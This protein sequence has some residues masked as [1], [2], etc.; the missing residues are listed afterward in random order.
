VAVP[1]GDSPLTARY[2]KKFPRSAAAALRLD[3]VVAGG[4]THDA[5]NLRPFGVLV[6]RAAGA[7]KWT[8]EGVRLID[9]W[10][11]HGALLCGHAYG[12][13]VEAVTRQ[14]ARGF[15]YGASHPLQIRW[16]ELIIGL[17]PGAE[18][19][20]F[21]ASATEATLLALQ[22]ARAVTGRK[23][24]VR[25]DGHFHGWYDSAMSYFVPAESSGFDT[26]STSEVRLAAGACIEDVVEVFD[27]TVAGLILEPGGGGSG[28]LPL[29]H[30]LLRELRRL[31]RA[32]G[33]V[34]IFDETVTGFRAAPGGVQALAD[35][36]PDLTVLGKILVGGLPGGALAGQ[37]WAMETFGAGTVHEGRHVRVL[38]TGTF[39]ANPLSAA[40]GVAMLEHVADGHHQRLA[41]AGASQLARLVNE[42]AAREGVD[43]ALF[44]QSGI[45]HVLIGAH[46]CGYP[47]APGAGAVLLPRDHADWY[48]SLR[49]ALLLRGVDSHPVHGWLS[50]AHDA[51]V[52]AKT[53]VAFREAFQDLRR[54]GLVPLHT[55]T[56]E[57]V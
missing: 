29:S 26:S 21:T 25:L 49:L 36:V 4:A 31:T 54:F 41:E 50:S 5:W 24:I 38:H 51:E 22:V 33:T 8:V 11:G 46:H 15:H 20:R 35:V 9:Y 23:V 39:N 40:A 28:A 45:F 52:I 32:N 19:V 7:H 55:G 10:M 47:V 37:R 57:T 3:Q 17:V 42:E 2:A 34:L 16:S 30:D 43:V 48:A 6:E 18:R 14:A 44:E 1:S 12:P 13:V 53:A 27:D 56:P